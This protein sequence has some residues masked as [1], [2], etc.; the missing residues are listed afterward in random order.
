LEEL[1]AILENLGKMLRHKHNSRCMIPVLQQCPVKVVG[2]GDESGLVQVLNQAGYRCKVPNN[3]MMSPTPNQHT[4]IELSVAHTEAA[5]ALLK[6]VGLAE[7]S[8]HGHLK[9][10]EPLLVVQ[11]HIPPTSAAEGII[12]PVLVPLI[13][14][15]PNSNNVQYLDSACVARY[16]SKYVASV[17]ECNRVYVRPPSDAS[18]SY[19]VDIDNVGNTKITSVAMALSKASKATKRKRHHI[20]RA[21]PQPEAIMFQLQ[22]PQ[23]YTDLKFVHV[24]SVPLEERAAFDKEA[25]IH[26]LRRQGVISGTISSHKDLDS[27]A[28]VPSHIARVAFGTSFPKWR[29]FKS[30]AL[31]IAT[32]LLLSPLTVDGTTT[33]EY[34]ISQAY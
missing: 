1:E 28:V 16:V 18:P 3:C 4:F 32:D 14:M 11:R 31:I 17:D 25:P 33:S 29:H 34:P 2:A 13:I 23:V 30:S 10:L 12:S 24:P 27:R 15:N 5:K 19:K 7:E 20:G 22:I 21:V 26:S 6:E 8:A 9:L